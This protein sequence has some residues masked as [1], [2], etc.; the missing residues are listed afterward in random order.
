MSTL[1]DLPGTEQEIATELC[2]RNSRCTG[3]SVKTAADRKYLKTALK[4]GVSR[5]GMVDGSPIFAHSDSKKYI[6]M[7]LSSHEP[8]VEESKITVLEP[9]KT[10]A[11]SAPKTTRTPLSL[12]PVS[13]PIET[14]SPEEMPVDPPQENVTESRKSSRLPGVEPKHS[15]PKSRSE[16][17]AEADRLRMTLRDALNGVNGLMREIKASRSRE[18]ELQKREQSLIK[19]QEQLRSTIAAISKI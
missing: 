14:E 16:L 9:G 11:S 1:L 7:P 8:D 6:W 5:F 3:T 2:L 15:V 17:E 12:A 10:T 13:V 4:M 18:R 19:Q